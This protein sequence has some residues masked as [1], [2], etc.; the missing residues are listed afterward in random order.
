MHLFRV[1]VNTTA[2]VSLGLI[3]FIQTHATIE[4][5]QINSKIEI[6]TEDK[7]N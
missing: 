4:L 3:E 6:A 1:I 2:P 7:P 5:C